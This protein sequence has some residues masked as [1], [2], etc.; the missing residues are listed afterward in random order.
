M[1]T[2][3]KDSDGD[4]AVICVAELTVKEVATM[5][6]NLTEVAPVKPVPV[7]V[8]IV[9]PAIGPELGETPVTVGTA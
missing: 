9:P 3:P 6:P 1:C 5:L 2:V 7:I 4:L 8:T